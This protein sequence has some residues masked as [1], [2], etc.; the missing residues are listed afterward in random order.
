MSESL[1]ERRVA[2][3]AAAEYGQRQAVQRLAPVDAGRGGLPAGGEPAGGQRRGCAGE[4]GFDAELQQ[5]FAGLLP[6]RVH[7]AEQSQAG[8]DLEQH[9]V[10]RGKADTRR[11]APGP[12]GD[13]GQQGGF[14]CRLASLQMQR[15]R[16]G[17][18]GRQGLAGKDPLGA[19][20]AIGGEDAAAAAAVDHAER[21]AVIGQAAGEDLQRQ[22]G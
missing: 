16:H 18:R 13:L 6:D 15:G 4:A 1:G 7:A 8:A 20:G 17:L 21:R 3:R 10:G 5:A 22:I 12:A 11:E 2:V 19:G 14:A 9:G